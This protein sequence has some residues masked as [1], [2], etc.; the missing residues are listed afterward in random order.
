MRTFVTQITTHGAGAQ[1]AHLEIV[2]QG[3]DFR[4]FSQIA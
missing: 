2:I 3:S 1:S 4:H